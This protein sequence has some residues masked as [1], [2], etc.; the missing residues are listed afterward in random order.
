MTR[1]FQRLAALASATLCILL[2]MHGMAVA[3]S[4]RVL[5]STDNRQLRSM[6]LDVTGYST[7]PSGSEETL[8]QEALDDARRR[9]LEIAR[10]DLQ[11]KIDSR[12]LNMHLA[13]LGEPEVAP[14]QGLDAGGKER[15][16]E[17]IARTAVFIHSAEKMEV[18]R[19]SGGAAA[20]AYALSVTAEVVYVLQPTD[21]EESQLQKP[22]PLPMAKPGQSP[23]RLKGEA[24]KKICED[25]EES[26]AKQILDALTT[27]G[28]DKSGIGGSETTLGS[29]QNGSENAP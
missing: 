22:P 24:G 9:A 11:G 26:M 15:S 28:A 25:A 8:R 10:K 1:S 16:A 5:V 3:Q 2:C 14:M 27:G 7:S 13:F 18:P 23:S 29:G 20:P 17:Q 12:H 19:H 6:V 21:G 4:F